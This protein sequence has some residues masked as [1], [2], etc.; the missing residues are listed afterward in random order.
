MRA[1]RWK[2]GK[3]SRGPSVEKHADEEPS[4]QRLWEWVI[5]H[6]G[7]ICGRGIHLVE[8]TGDFYMFHLGFGEDEKRGSIQ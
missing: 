6:A 8:I 4:R 1:G 7:G 3:V 2:G 5:R